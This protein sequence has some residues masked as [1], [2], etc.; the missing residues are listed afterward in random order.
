MPRPERKKVDGQ[1][2]DNPLDTPLDISPDDVTLTEDIFVRPPV[3][4]AVRPPPADAPSEAAN[5]AALMDVKLAKFMEQIAISTA[6]NQQTRTVLW[7][8]MQFS[9]G[10]AKS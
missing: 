6:T 3:D 10:G 8:I 9:A 1:V 7:Q 4:I 5:L 2:R